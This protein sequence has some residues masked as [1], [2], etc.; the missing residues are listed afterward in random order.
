MSQKPQ[1]RAKLTFI[2]SDQGGRKIPAR[3][4]TRSQLKVNDIFTSCIVR[5]ENEEQ[6]F[7]FGVEYD[8]TLEL[9]FW[10]CYKDGIYAGMPLQLN[11]GDRAVGFGTI[12]AIVTQ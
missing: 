2:A 7:E 3:S 1:V 4:G 6:V 12:E 9:L 10:D 8:V 11:E 5:S